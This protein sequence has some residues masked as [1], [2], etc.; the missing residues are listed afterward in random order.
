MSLK[1]ELSLYLCVILCGAWCRDLYSGFGF[2]VACQQ[3]ITILAVAGASWGLEQ[4][5]ACEVLFTTNK[6]LAE[7][8]N[9]FKWFWNNWIFII[10][11]NMI[12][13][14]E[15]NQTHP[16]HILEPQGFAL[17]QKLHYFSPSVFY[18]KIAILRDMTRNNSLFTIPLVITQTQVL[19]TYH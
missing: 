2:A 6:K 10:N 17:R 13:E 18:I 12:Y 16:Q 3:F 7:Q 8:Y 14:F 15:K 11:I 1:K 4:S 5:P 9:A 19:S